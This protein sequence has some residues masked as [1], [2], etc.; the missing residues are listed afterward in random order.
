MNLKN[1]TMVLG[2]GNCGCKIAKLF[3]D[4]GY[5]A[6]F[7]N[8]SE[9][10]LKV[11][12][13]IKNIYKLNG[14]DGFGGHRERADDCFDNNPDFK[15]A[16]KAIEQRIVVLIY[17]VGG[18]TG[19]GLSSNVAMHLY[20]V[21]KGEK[22]V[23]TVPVLPSTSE[24]IN[25]HKNAYQAVQELAE[26]TEVCGMGA[27]FFISNEGQE[28]LTYVNKTFYNLFNAFLTD[29]SWGEQNNFDESERIEMLSESGAMLICLKKYGEGLEKLLT[30]NIFAPLQND[31]VCGNIGII[32]TSKDDVSIDGIVAELGK[33]LNIYEGYRGKGTLISASGLSFPLDHVTNLGK[34]AME[35]QAERRRT[36]EAAKANALPSLDFGEVKKKAPARLEKNGAAEGKKLTGKEA[37][38]AL[39]GKKKQ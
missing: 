10:D 14:F 27:S 31:K 20:D 36:V 26:L 28:N 1:K 18:S 32:H 11:L 9:Q 38:L 21:Y 7:A 30:D 8:G 12:G 2:L 16:L 5:A 15:E 19:S 37:L 24:S 33:P 29:D 17:A 23:V 3:A 39:R 25:K 6:M 13:N 35:G 4:N 34:L 22:I